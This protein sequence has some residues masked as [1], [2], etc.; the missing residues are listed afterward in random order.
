MDD[1]L[2]LWQ[3]A[4]IDENTD[5]NSATLL[6]DRFFVVRG[7]LNGLD[8]RLDSSAVSQEALTTN[9]GY[10]YI[11]TYIHTYTVN[12]VYSYYDYFQSAEHKS[13]K[14]YIT[15]TLMHA[16][17]HIYILMSIHLLFKNN[18]YV[19]HTYILDRDARTDF[20][21]HNMAERQVHPYFLSMTES[22]KQLS[23]P[24]E[25]VLI[26]TLYIH[27]YHA[28]MYAQNLIIFSRIVLY[29]DLS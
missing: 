27:T 1:L 6:Q 3:Q 14:L 19:I 28:H 17:I 9:F 7:L 15:Y 16:Y 12:N 11:H 23:M 10:T 8:Y 5:E 2:R 26:H 4:P 22:W 20:Y 29:S 13:I 25:V 24:A 18:I 21:P